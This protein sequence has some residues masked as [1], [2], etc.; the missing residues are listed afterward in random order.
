[1]NCSDNSN[2]EFKLQGTHVLINVDLSGSRRV[3]EAMDQERRS[4][5]AK[6]HCLNPTR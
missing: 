2:H 3:C 5:I 1:M 6:G 4:A